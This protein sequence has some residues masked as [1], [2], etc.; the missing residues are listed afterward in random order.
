MEVC[1]ALLHLQ[2]HSPGADAE[3]A[4]CNAHGV[5]VFESMATVTQWL[6]ERA[7]GGSAMPSCGRRQR[8]ARRFRG[9]G[10][11][12]GR[13]VGSPAAPIRFTPQG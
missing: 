9:D 4:W 6:G 10:C 2:G 13:G 12:G 7:V 8:H 11:G 3:V 1:G 5:P